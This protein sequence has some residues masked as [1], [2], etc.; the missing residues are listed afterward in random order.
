MKIPASVRLAVA[1]ASLLTI[2]LQA[3]NPLNSWARRA[4]PGLTSSLFDVAY[5]N[6]I[7]VAVGDNS[8]VVTS[9]DGANWTL[10]SPG[11]YGSLRRVRFVN[12]E[13]AAVGTSD[14]ILFSSDGI[15]W[16]PRTLPSA[17]SWDVAYG[18]GVY[19]VAGS[20][21]YVSSN[22]IDWVRISTP[23]SATMDSVVFGNGRFVATRVTS[24]PSS[25][26]LYST[27][28]TDWL[29]GGNA[30]TSG[31]GHQGLGDLIFTDGIFLGAGTLGG[32]RGIHLSTDGAT[33]CCGFFPNIGPANSS[34][35]LAYG[36]GYFLWAVFESPD[37]RQGQPLIHSSTN[38]TSWEVLS[39]AGDAELRGYPWGAA[40][41]NGTFVFVGA[42]GYIIQSGNLDGIPLIAVQ[43]QDRA[44]VV[45]NPA[46]FS[47]RAFGSLPL[48]YQWYHND[49]IIPDATNTTH[50]IPQVQ[51]SHSGGYKVVI[52][53][54]FGSVTSRVA[55]LAVSFLEI[56][57]YAGI[58]ILGVPGRTYRIEATL[59]SGS[60]N[61]Q[62]LTN[63]VLPQ[64]P[65]IWIDY[66][67]PEVGAR[68]YRAAEL[69]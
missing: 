42:N 46:S 67:S 40:Y 32:T 35:G 51:V 18:N 9:T 26:S 37:Q 23:G 44:A 7:F 57:S 58:T 69:Q 38:G 24:F 30:P 61:W 47:V 41:G 36:R 21:A 59:A 20:S 65:H 49:A 48:A 13:F 8:R 12:G 16:T 33:W 54:S 29:Q 52:T 63:L 2:S 55:Q 53:N 27:N 66:E 1:L 6:G 43:P 15:A 25:Q 28:G 4:V 31:N 62:T 56:D 5:S 34:A 10:S 19:V 45:D 3:Q 17:G 50:T 39:V 11:A 64:T 22:G 68:L 60:P 14:K